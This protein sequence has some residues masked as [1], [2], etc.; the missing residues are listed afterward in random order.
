[1]IPATAPPPLNQLTIS[2]KTSDRD[3]IFYAT[4]QDTQVS[5][6]IERG[7]LL[8]L[9]ALLFKHLQ[10]S[11]SIAG[12]VISRAK[13]ETARIQQLCEGLRSTSPQVVRIGDIA[14]Y[15]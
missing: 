3:E 15:Y 4:S 10:R 1:M 14:Y 8:R 13:T 11:Y 12:T 6:D 9:W 2:Y 7:P 5:E